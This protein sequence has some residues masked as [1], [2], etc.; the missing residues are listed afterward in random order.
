MIAEQDR[1]ALETLLGQMRR[2]HAELNDRHAGV[3]V[4]HLEAAVAS[5]ESH[6]RRKGLSA[7]VTEQTS[8]AAGHTA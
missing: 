8:A 3:C 6:L 5:L 2:I 1:G 7:A 4:L